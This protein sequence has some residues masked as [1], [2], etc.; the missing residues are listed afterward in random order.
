M[1]ISES[2]I[3]DFFERFEAASNG[4]VWA[5][6]ADLIHPDAVYRFTEGDV[7]GFDAIRG[8][9]ERTWSKSSNVQDERYY[10]TDLDVI[11]ADVNSAAVTY[12]YHWSGTIDGKQP[13]NI[14]G[15][16]TNVIVRNGD[17]LQFILEHLSR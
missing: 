11:N 3:R 1:S 13:F 6:V 8:A 16:G 12:G 9:F 15:R 14:H 5:D 4:K 17:K 7:V 10:L 2:E